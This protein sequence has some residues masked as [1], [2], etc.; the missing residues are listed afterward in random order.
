MRRIFLILI[1]SGLMLAFNACSE[2]SGNGTGPDNDDNKTTGS[3]LS[4]ESWSGTEPTNWTTSNVPNLYANISKSDDAQA[5]SS[6]AKGEI[7]SFQGVPLNA[8]I[9]SG[10]LTLPYFEI[11]QA[12]SKVKFYYKFFPQI[13]GESILVQISLYDDYPNGLLGFESFKIDQA[14]SS[15]TMYN[16]EM[17]PTAST[18][19]KIQISFASVGTQIGTYFIID[20]FSWE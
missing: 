2:S 4:F 14:S 8:S 11:D 6:A 16:V 12:V 9:T 17:A 5:G 3:Y 10:S 1:S 15:Y 13:E 18:P 7:I 20:N 19:K